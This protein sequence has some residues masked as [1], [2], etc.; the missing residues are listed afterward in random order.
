MNGIGTEVRGDG[1]A[2][3]VL[4]HR[5]L[6]KNTAEPIVVVVQCTLNGCEDGLGEVG[7]VVLGAEIAHVEPQG[8]FYEFIAAAAVISFQPAVHAVDHV[9][10]EPKCRFLFHFFFHRCSPFLAVGQKGRECRKHRA[11]LETRLRFF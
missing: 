11:F 7:G 9:G 10:R 1:V 3:H 5:A 8:L 6:E 2:H 4:L